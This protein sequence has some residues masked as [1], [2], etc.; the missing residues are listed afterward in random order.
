MR[1]PAFLAFLLSTALCLPAQA[2]TDPKEDPGV[3]FQAV[4]KSEVISVLSGGLKPGTQYLGNL[5]LTLDMDL[6]KLAGWDDTQLF[7]YFLAVHG[8]DPSAENIGDFQVR[9]NIEADDTARLY[10]AWL[11]KRFLEDRLSL[12]V[13]LYD[14]NSEFD[15]M[16]TA[17]YFLNSS[18]GIGAD[19][20]QTG[21]NG[22]SIFPVTS[23]AARL[24]YQP[25]PG[26]YAQVALLD[27]VPGDS[28]RPYG[29][30]MLLHP[31][32]GLLISGELGSLQGEDPENDP[33]GKIA[34]GAW[35]FTEPFEDVLEATELGEPV[36]RSGN[37]GAYILAE[38]K[39]YRES[40]DPG[41]GLSLFARYGI[42][43]SRVNQLSSYAGA[44]LAYRGP[45]PDRDE[46]VF[47]LA[48]AAARNGAAFRE[49]QP[50]LG[51]P[52]DQWEVSL[53]LTYRAQV[54]PWLAI[55]PDL[56]YIVNPGMDPSLENAFTAGVR[57]EIAP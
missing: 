12:R 27:G 3:Q 13:G 45:F 36:M 22:P 33:D 4:Y 34:V 10:E 48:V 6:E 29:T 16:E 40:A 21:L 44:G 43:D 15:K 50:A 38:R 24:R 37:H 55:Q 30:H 41:Q 47:G 39:V 52:V 1:Y 8:G 23:L 51:S 28:D 46:D 31:A 17:S 9:S 25:E 35:T 49:A 57:F 18:H 5:D 2:Q 11:E 32:D 53:E 20:A 42:A 54:T 19:Y 14:L 26:F 7:L 56:Q